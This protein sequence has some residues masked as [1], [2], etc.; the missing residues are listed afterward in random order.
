MV[1]PR[2]LEAKALHL[3]FV[4]RVLKIECY[5]IDLLLKGITDETSSNAHQHLR[6]TFSDMNNY[7][8]AGPEWLLPRAVLHECVE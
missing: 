6:F 1:N 8:F 3:N 2:V 5:I 4:Q 7:D